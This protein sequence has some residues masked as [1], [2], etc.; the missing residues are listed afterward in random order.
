MRDRERRSAGDALPVGG[1]GRG[2]RLRTLLRPRPTPRPTAV[3]SVRGD[4]RGIELRWGGVDR[5]EEDRGG[6]EEV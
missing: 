4:G 2:V 1:E 6:F 5:E 3:D